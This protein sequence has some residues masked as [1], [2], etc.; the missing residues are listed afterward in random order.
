MSTDGKIK[1]DVQEATPGKIVE[2]YML[3]A[4]DQGVGAI[5]YF[6]AGTVS[7]TSSVQHNSI[8]YSPLDVQIEGMEYTSQGQLP[9][10]TVTIGNISKTIQAEVI[11]H[12]DLL[13]AKLTR[14]RTF[15]KY[16]D[17]QPEAD[18]SAIFADDVYYFNRKTSH[19]KYLIKWELASEI[20]YEGQQIPGRVVL[21]DICTHTYR[22][23]DTGAGDFVAGT[24]DYS[25]AS[26]YD[27]Y[28]NVCGASD[29]KCGKKLSDCELRYDVAEDKPFRG[30]PGV[31]KV[32]L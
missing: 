2:L 29:D 13:G 14:R 16:L 6:T 26:Y 5:I 25:G 9:T 10:P 11:A 1:S 22:M 8:T 27:E 31:A 20:S 19:N 4:T 15:E 24:C 17:G 30:F 3:D 21:R 23:W 28:G 12:N 32:R 7:G 18:S